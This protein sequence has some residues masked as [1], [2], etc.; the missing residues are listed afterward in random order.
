MMLWYARLCILCCAVLHTYSS[1]RELL[2][3]V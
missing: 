2:L 3:G 1:S